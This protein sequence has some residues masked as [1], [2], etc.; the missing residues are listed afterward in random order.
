LA[1]AVL[2][3]H[4]RRQQAGFGD[5]EL[6]AH[7]LP[8]FSLLKTQRVHSRFGLRFGVVTGLPALRRV[9]RTEKQVAQN[10]E[11]RANKLWDPQA[12]QA[13]SRPVRRVSTARPRAQPRLRAQLRVDGARVPTPGLGSHRRRSG[14]SGI[15]ARGRRNGSKCARHGR[16]P[17]PRFA[18]HVGARTDGMGSEGPREA[19]RARGSKP[20]RWKARL[21]H[22]VGLDLRARPFLLSV[23][24][25]VPRR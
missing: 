8:A 16:P 12:E 14:C 19:P 23:P 24:V 3:A 7:F 17:G 6:R 25:T 21:P 4:T 20:A 22:S 1:S 11:G 9:G 15:R 13:A 5:A 18:A 10:Q 2:L